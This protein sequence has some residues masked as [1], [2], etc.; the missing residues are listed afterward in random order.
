MSSN[1]ND[2]DDIIV[3]KT[4]PDSPIE[5]TEKI[6]STVDNDDDFIVFDE[7]TI[8]DDVDLEAIESESESLSNESDEE[9][10]SV[11]SVYEKKY[12]KISEV[13]SIIGET[14]A[15]IRFWEESFAVFGKNFC[16][17]RTRGGTRRFTKENIENLKLLKLLLRERRLTIEGAV[18]EIKN[19]RKRNAKERALILLM[20][21]RDEL[22]N[23]IDAY[24][25]FLHQK[26]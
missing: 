20:E 1:I 10:D 3:W 11:D 12:Y 24:N 14:Q 18:S 21:T 2:S 22:N 23:M 8:D 19:D 7:D 4:S 9:E 13:E 15:T 17:H 16:S 26:C 25:Y 5:K 6:A